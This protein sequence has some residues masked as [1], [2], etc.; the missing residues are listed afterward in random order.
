M[1]LRENI[2]ALLMADSPDDATRQ[3]ELLH[4]I[5]DAFDEGGKEAVTARLTEYA[6]SIKK[7]SNRLLEVLRKKLIGGES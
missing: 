4:E 2:E 3:R 1:S 5:L 7:E 6:A